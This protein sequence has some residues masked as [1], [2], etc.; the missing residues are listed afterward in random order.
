MPKA[1]PVF[2]MGPSL[3]QVR[4][5]RDQAREADAR[6]GNSAERG[7]GEFWRGLRK[8]ILAKAPLCVR[9]DAAGR[10]RPAVLVHHIVPLRHGGK[11]SPDNLAPL[12]R[13]C[14]AAAHSG[15]G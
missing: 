13:D 9:C 1:A 10:V 14:H 2:R 4:F 11:H 3:P 8:R 5:P 6:R 7:Y 15:G 12:C